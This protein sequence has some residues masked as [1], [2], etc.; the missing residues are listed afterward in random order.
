MKILALFAGLGA[1]VMS[2]MA[3]A[4][5]TGVFHAHDG[6]AGH[7]VFG[8]DHLIMLLAVAGVFGFV[9]WRSR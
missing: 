1:L 4:H 2:G 3:Q 9:L 7:P 8:V 6:A 5:E